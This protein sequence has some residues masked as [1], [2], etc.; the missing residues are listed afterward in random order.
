M[1]TRIEAI[2]AYRPRLVFN[3]TAQPDQVVDFLAM[4]TGANKG[5]VQLILDE[6]HDAVIFFNLQGTPVK[7]EGLGTYAPSIDTDGDLDIAHRTDAEIIKALNVPGAY[8]GV[9]EHRENIGK[10]TQDFIAM[11][12]KDHPDDPVVP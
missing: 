5:T 7:V 11:W 12:N 10:T 1:A 9:I 2:N 4:R 6:M 3:P 8:K